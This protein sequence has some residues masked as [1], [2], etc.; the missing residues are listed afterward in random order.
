MKHY[1]HPG[2]KEDPRPFRPW[3]IYAVQSVTNS[4]NGSHQT[5]EKQIGFQEVHWIDFFAA[6]QQVHDAVKRKGPQYSK[7][8][9]VQTE[10]RHPVAVSRFEGKHH[11][12]T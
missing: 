12:Y 5:N 9:W 8:D 7:S 10:V 6:V 4:K 2:E 3:N 1:R 11:E